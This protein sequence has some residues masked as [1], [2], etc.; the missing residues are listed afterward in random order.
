M[1]PEYAMHGLFSVKSD[2]YSFGVLLLELVTGQKNNY[3]RVEHT[4]EDLISF[5]WDSWRAGSVATMIDPVIVNGPRNEI[6]RCIHIGLLCVQESVTAR[7]TMASVVTMLNSFSVA[8]PPPSEPAFYMHMKAEQHMLAG[9]SNSKCIFSN[10]SKNEVSITE[11][12][13]R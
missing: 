2:V 6:M 12:E 4:V 7:P 5:A 11:M 13:P 10:F 3:F 1:A 8:L 9:S